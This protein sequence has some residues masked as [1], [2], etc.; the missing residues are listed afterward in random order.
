[1]RQ[2]AYLIGIIFVWVTGCIGRN[3]E[4]TGK[5][6]KNV[7]SI[8]FCHR[9]MNATVVW[10]DVQLRNTGRGE[11]TISKM[12]VRGNETCAFD[13]SYAT[14]ATAS[15]PKSVA[16][17]PERNAKSFKPVT[18]SPSGALLIRVAYTPSEI[19][20]EDRADLL[21]SS[22]AENL[23]KQL[24]I[25]MCGAG[26]YGTAV[27]G[28][29]GAVVDGGEVVDASIESEDAGIDSMECEACSAPLDKDAPYCEE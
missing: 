20:L 7:D 15:K 21:I 2:H 26:W 25:P 1:M 17:P 18:L 12:A 10:N 11:L 29:V 22:D 13:V 28:G 23:D 19:A 5:L 24:V 27:D 9:E 4:E 3:N 6:E 16:V 14:G 8:N